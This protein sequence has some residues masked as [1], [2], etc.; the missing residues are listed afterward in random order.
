MGERREICQQLMEGLFLFSVDSQQVHF[1]QSPLLLFTFDRQ[2]QRS[3]SFIASQASANAVTPT[4][5]STEMELETVLQDPS[6][7]LSFVLFLEQTHLAWILLFYLSVES[8]KHQ[9]QCNPQEHDEG[10][11]KESEVISR[12]SIVRTTPG[13]SFSSVLSSPFSAAVK[14]KRINDL[15][16]EGKFSR[17]IHTTIKPVDI[18]AL[19]EKEKYLP[20]RHQQHGSG[21]ALMGK[22]YDFQRAVLDLLKTQQFPR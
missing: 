21:N 19:L 7:C 5:V 6:L 12:R 15:F 3:A 1:Q 2:S 9:E 20:R 4:T 17:R 13:S 16:L 14:A 10:N 18:P 11:K 22:L 8:L